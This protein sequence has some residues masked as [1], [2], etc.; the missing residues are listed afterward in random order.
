MVAGFP[1]NGPYVLSP[2]RVRDVVTAVGE[3]IYGRAEVT[4]EVYSLRAEVR[5]GNS[6]GP[7]LDA[8]GTVV[9]VVFARSLDD[10]RDRLRASRWPR[11]APVLQAAAGRPARCPPGP[12]PPAD[13][14]ARSR[15]RR[16]ATRWRRAVRDHRSCRLTGPRGARA[17]RRVR[18]SG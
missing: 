1:L 15:S 11:P 2:G 7:V 10:A 9:G 13:P 16:P 17:G 12:A 5:P 18:G 3:D 8:A 14:P 4:R 6:G